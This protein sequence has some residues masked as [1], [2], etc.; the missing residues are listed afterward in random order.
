MTSY[1]ISGTMSARFLLLFEIPLGICEAFSLR[2]AVVEL[3]QVARHQVF[4]LAHFSYII[5]VV[6]GCTGLI[7][8]IFPYVIHI[9]SPLH[10]VTMH[11]KLSRNFLSFIFLT[12]V[13]RCGKVCTSCTHSCNNTYAVSAIYSKNTRKQCC[14]RSGENVC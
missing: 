14:Y 5:L 8:G 13:H 3:F 10:C 2:F 4:M 9:V 12:Y 7:L 6:L 11:P 1:I